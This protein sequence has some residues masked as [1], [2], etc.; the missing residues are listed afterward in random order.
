MG[1]IQGWSPESMGIAAAKLQSM[2]YTYL[3]AG[4]MAVLRSPQI[5][6]CLE[7]IRGA[8]RRDVGLHIL[9][10]AKADDIFEFARHNIT[11]LDTTSPLLR[12][13]KDSR[14]TYF[15]PGENGKLRYY[16][17]IRIPQALENLTLK[18][19]VKIGH[20]MQEKLVEL[21]R[22][23][24]TTVRAFDRDEASV[25]E[26]LDATTKYAEILLT[27]PD[28][29][30]RPV[31]E[32]KLLD[33]RRRYQETLEDRPWRECSCA[34][35]AKISVEVAIFRSSNR[36]KRRGIHNLHVYHHHIRSNEG[37]VTSDEQASLFSH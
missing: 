19:L 20:V 22:K 27:E 5:H 11:S 23:A 28:P 18:R 3:S 1:V 33:L 21:E 25:E 7:A 14:V 29:D 12:A 2:G 35:C 31:P 13:F 8:I 37:A 36:N 15:L 24:L 30:S 26:T 17:A 9:G 32:T 16:T 4:G 10:F 6:A 34:I